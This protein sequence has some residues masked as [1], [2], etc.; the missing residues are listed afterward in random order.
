MLP[1]RWLKGNFALHLIVLGCVLHGLLNGC[2]QSIVSTKRE[3]DGVRRTCAILFFGASSLAIAGC[4]GG[5]RAMP[6]AVVAQQVPFSIEDRCPNLADADR[7]AIA[8]FDNSTSMSHTYARDHCVTLAE[9]ERRLTIESSNAAAILMRQ[10]ADA[11]PST[12][13]GLWIEHQPQYHVKVAFTR[14]AAATLA[15]YTRDPLFEPVERPGPSLVELREE[16][17]R[18]MRDLETIGASF[19]SGNVNEQTGRGEITLASDIEP[20]RQAENEGRILVPDYVDLIAPPVFKVAVPP[21]F[22][23]GAERLAAFPRAKFRR[24]GIS[25]LMGSTRV[26]PYILN[27][28]LV[29]D[30]EDGPYTVLWPNEAKPDLSR[31]GIIEIVD[32]TNGKRF[33]VGEAIA[34]EDGVALDTSNVPAIDEGARCPAPYAFVSNFE[35]WADY[36][37]AQ[38]EW[39]AEALARDKQIPIEAARR[40]LKAMVKWQERLQAFGQGLATGIPA[41]YGGMAVNDGRATLYWVASESGSSVAPIPPALTD[42]ITIVGVPRP[43]AALAQERTDLRLQLAAVG[44]KARV[45]YEIEKGRLTMSD[46]ADLP[47][48]ARFAREGKVRLP[49]NIEIVTDGATVSGLFSDENRRRAEAS[50]LSSPDFDPIVALASQTPVEA[51]L[52]GGEEGGP[53]RMPGIA[54]AREVATMLVTMGFTQAEVVALREAGLDPVSALIARNGR[55]TPVN[56]AIL[57]RHVVIV[58]PVSIES[59]AQL[60]DGY[61]TSAHVRV[62]ETLK[63][64][65]KVGDVLGLRLVSGFDAE[66]K[67][68]QDNEEP[69][70]L[71]G[72]PRAFAPGTRWLLWL[73]DG[74]YE[75]VARFA[76]NAPAEG[77]WYGPWFSIAQVDDTIASPVQGSGAVVL[78]TRYDDRAYRLEDLRRDLA[79]V[80]AASVMLEAEQ[81]NPGAAQPASNAILQEPGLLAL[82]FSKAIEQ[83]VHAGK[84]VC[85]S[86]SFDGSGPI[87]PPLEIVTALAKQLGVSA[88]PGSSCGSNAHP[89]VKGSGERAML[90]A[91][92]FMKEKRGTWLLRATAIYG[93]LGAEGQAYHLRQTSRGWQAE[94]TGERWI[95]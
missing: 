39:R 7:A 67:W 31:N 32:R 23:G 91:L 12:F 58:E 42:Y 69:M 60:G 95:S 68:Q 56:R 24:S 59:R 17:A 2:D 26:Q 22:P 14:D 19:S 87:D 63:G 40:E 85:L 93:N 94:P 38:N 86:Y 16:T 36:E 48:L 80:Q 35:P 72:L 54:Q 13:A 78:P 18:V 66:G 81:N 8:R 51:I 5:N 47:A 28:C 92:R 37:A 20:V 41:Q 52:A 6:S 50:I 25:L 43:L 62:T 70:L 4:A 65:A 44:L 74:L 57:S 3:C 77:E 21:P 53:P 11:E 46:V 27:R 82:G 9:A 33:A 15:R 73:P 30:T 45:G 90:Y 79:P 34:V 10:V 49:G 76:G 29:I 75:R 55:S 89:F 61:R 83:T 71:E 88:Y 84:P 64:P 1:H